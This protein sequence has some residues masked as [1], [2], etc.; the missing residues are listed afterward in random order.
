MHNIAGGFPHWVR[1]FFY[2]FADIESAQV[3][4]QWITHRFHLKMNLVPVPPITQV[5]WW[6]KARSGVWAPLKG[7]K[8][9]KST[10]GCGW[11]REARRANK[12][13]FFFF[14]DFIYLFMRDSER[15]RGRSRLHAGSPMRDL[16][17]G[18]QDHALSQRQTLNHWATQ[19]PL[20]D[21][22]FDILNLNYY[23]Y[24]WFFFFFKI[25]FIYSWHSH[26]EREA[27][28]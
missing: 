17:P 13:F 4:C 22:I 7:P 6:E 25:L 23:F 15:G 26:T 24:T 14:L 8:S 9:G 28:T 3:L 12:N 18:L 1:V 21:L 16:I 27:E 19:V 20:T 11:G 10:R 5:V 2:F